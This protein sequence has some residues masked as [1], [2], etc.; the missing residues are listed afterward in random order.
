MARR[1]LPTRWR[2]GGHELVES[3]AARAGA[4]Q[5]K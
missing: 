2:V 3:V 1:V 5:S 4:L